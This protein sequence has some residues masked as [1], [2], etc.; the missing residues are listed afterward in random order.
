MSTHL[1]TIWESV[2]DAIPEATAIVQG[3]RRVAWQEFDDRAARLASVFA[4]SG[5]DVGA[6][7]AIFLYNSIEYLETY[8]AALK[9]RLTPFN[10]NY[11]YLDDELLYLFDNA[12]AE[13]VVVHASLGSRL[14]N[15]IDRLAQIKVVVV[16]DDL[17]NAGAADECN[18]LR[19]GTAE[20]VGYEAALAAHAPAPRIERTDDDITMTYTG[21]T[22]GLPK[23]VINKV[24]PAGA[25][26]MVT[27]PPLVGIPPIT[28]VA[29]IPNVARQLLNDGRQFTALPAPPLMHATGLS[30]GAIPALFLGGKVV[31]LEGRGLDVDELWS[32][33]E[34]EGVNSIT[35]VG[36]PFARPMLRGLREGPPR[37]ISSLI[38]FSSSGAMFSSDIKLG[39]HELVPN[40]FILD[41]IAS[42]EGAMG[43]SLSTAARPAATGRFTPNP[44]VIVVADDDSDA[45]RILQPGSEEIGFIAVLGGAEGY[46]KDEVKTAK[47]FRIINGERYT[48]PG[49]FAMLDADGSIVLLGRG[50]QC[51]NTGGEKVFPEE[52]EEVIKSNVAIDDCLIFGV[53]DERF[54]QRVVGVVSRAPG[55]PATTID[56]ILSDARTRLASYKLP[57]EL[58]AVDVVPRTAAGKADYGTAAQLFEGRAV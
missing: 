14:S 15:I 43:I 6:K 50:S 19:G 49:D 41:F 58:V 23:G 31:L 48:I 39:L 25:G 40:A 27:L 20:W 12:D 16:V 46:Y 29:E 45:V 9:N 32:A 52:V 54:G 34:R 55:A 47:T 28:D 18:G 35:I 24:A 37:D 30:I 36:D 51:I 42:T 38:A 11:R 13:A 10:V 21:G 53:A 56:D 2:A 44:G 1:A 33:V 26:L 7:V 57:R 22:T 3:D 8:N 5:L 4:A 17:A